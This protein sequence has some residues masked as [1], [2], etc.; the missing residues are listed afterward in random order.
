MFR[1]W[2]F[3][4][5]I[6][7][8][9][10]FAIGLAATGKFYSMET[11]DTAGYQNMDWSSWT[12]A[13][14][15][16]RTPGYPAFL[17]AVGLV[18]TDPRSVPIAHFFAHAIS[19]VVLYYGLQQLTG[20]WIR[21]FVASSAVIYSRIMF[22]YFSTIATDSLAAAVGI[23]VC[24]L[25]MLR[26]RS[27]GLLTSLCLALSVAAGWLIRPSYLYLIPF[28]PVSTWLIYRIPC[29]SLSRSRTWHTTSAF[30]LVVVP[31]ILYCSLRLAT[32][33]RFGIVSFGGYNLLG[34]AG[35]FLNQEDI[36]R[37]SPELQPLAAK[38]I[39]RRESKSFQSIPFA[40]LP[41]SNY[42]RMENHYDVTIWQIFT[43]SASPNSNSVLQNSQLRQLA[44][45]LI[46]LHPSDYVTWL[47]KASRQAVRKLLWDFADNGFGF[48]L[49]CSA[50]GLLVLT[51]TFMYSRNPKSIGRGSETFGIVSVMAILYCAMSLAVVIPVCPPLG[52]FTDAASALLAAPLAVWILDTI[53]QLNA[54]IKCKA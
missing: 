16:M 15:G 9:F 49:L 35:Q 43:D 27:P 4:A 8:L 28:V 48:L 52:R 25:V 32:V 31:L 13:M 20:D 30:L 46:A 50:T 21:P 2:T 6:T 36:P 23:F 26:L 34:I 19:V 40:D 33:G 42:M 37:L 47:I 24:G 53:L 10:V 7:Q 22:C 3:F 54:R 51:H 38:A 45:E 18:S 17:K 39:E 41:K 5:L 12:A 29:A 44:Q 1:H 14:S 11:V